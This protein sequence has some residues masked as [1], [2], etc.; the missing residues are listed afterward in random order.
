[1]V[2]KLTGTVYSKENEWKLSIHEFLLGINFCLFKKPDM[3]TNIIS[4]IFY[5][6]YSFVETTFHYNK[7][8]LIIVVLH[9]AVDYTHFS[10]IL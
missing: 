5:L 1:M 9:F 8:R 4:I 3:L 10:Y 6:L 2:F 7:I